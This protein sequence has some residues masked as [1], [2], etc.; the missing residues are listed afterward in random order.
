MRRRRREHQQH[1]P[2]GLVPGRPARDLGAAVALQQIR[3]LHEV[4]DHGVEAHLGVLLGD[5]LEGSLGGRAQRP[6][7]RGGILPGGQ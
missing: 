6:L 7:R 4:R 2:D 1:Q 5:G 3:Q